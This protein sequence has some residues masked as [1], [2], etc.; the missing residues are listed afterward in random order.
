MKEIISRFPEDLIQV[1]IFGDDCILNKSIENWP[2]VE[3]LIAFY[4]TGYPLEKAIAYVELTK[5]FLVNDL[6]MQYIL[7]NRKSVYD[8]RID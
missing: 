2:V 7:Q 5:P 4:S 3:C 1:I 8:V 6:K